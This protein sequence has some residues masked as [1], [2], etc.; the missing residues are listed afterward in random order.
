M[1][2]DLFVEEQNGIATITFNRPDQRN[3]I[4]YEGWIKLREIANNLSSSS[5]VRVVVLT[6]AGDQAFSAGADIKDFANHRNSSNLAKDYS[7]AFDGAMDAIESIEKPTISLIKGFCIGG[8]CELSLAT[9]I[10]IASNNARFGVP[11]AHL[12]ILVGYKEM[13]RLVSLIGP[14]NTSYLLLS[15][16]IISAETA[17]QIGLIN[18]LVSTQDADKVCYSL[19]NEMAQLA[20]LSHKGHKEILQTVLK[21]PSLSNLNEEES[22]LPFAIFDSLDFQEGQK[23]FVAGTKPSFQGR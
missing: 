20:P 5:R 9:D 18:S 21:N 10:R 13:R 3:A 6:G 14:G 15:G 2:S 17:F 23:S 11:V 19:A 7:I 1:N 8:G 4:N 16:K 22:D 12:G